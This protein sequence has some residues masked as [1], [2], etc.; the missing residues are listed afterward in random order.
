GAEGERRPLGW[1]RCHHSA[2]VC[3][4]ASNKGEPRPIWRPAGVPPFGRRRG[5]SLSR[6]STKWYD[7]YLAASPGHTAVS[8]SASVVSERDRGHCSC[9][10]GQ[11]VTFQDSA[12][13][14]SAECHGERLGR[15]GDLG[16]D[17]DAVRP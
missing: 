11:N 2:H 13:P 14:L 4:V 17:H 8:N 15:L 12:V 7:L 1:I 6:S 3:C 9:P 10:L 5:K 16:V